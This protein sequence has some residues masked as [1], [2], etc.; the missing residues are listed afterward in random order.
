MHLQ[1]NTVK[2]VFE[3][4]KGKRKPSKP[5]APKSAAKETKADGKETK[6]DAAAAAAAA[7]AAEKSKLDYKRKLG[8]WE[9][10][11]KQ[12]DAWTLTQQQQNAVDARLSSL[13]APTGLVSRS[14]L[15]FKRQG[16]PALLCVL[17]I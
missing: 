11:A 8:E 14:R 16:L 15:P 5:A 4:L 17:L 2:H 13:L 10:C 3:V 6:A 1:L 12:H 9:R 7:A